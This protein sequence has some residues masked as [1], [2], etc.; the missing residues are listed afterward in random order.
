MSHI[1]FKKIYLTLILVIS[2]ILHITL[3]THH[4]DEMGGLSGESFY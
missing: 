3:H 1:F 4:L 2:I